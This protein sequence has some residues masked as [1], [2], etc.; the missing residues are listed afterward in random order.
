MRIGHKNYDAIKQFIS[1]K[2]VNNER[3]NMCKHDSTCKC[4]I[5]SKII[6]MPYPKDAKFR[7]SR[8]LELPLLYCR[9]F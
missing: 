5:K 2:Y 7:P 1:E 3:L 4:C 9:S 8:C 6:Y